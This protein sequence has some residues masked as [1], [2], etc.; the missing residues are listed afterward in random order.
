MVGCVRVW[1][2]TVCVRVKLTRSAD[3][4]CRNRILSIVCNA[5]AFR[6]SSHSRF[7]HVLRS[8]NKCAE[9]NDERAWRLATCWRSR[10]GITGMHYEG[11]W[12]V[13]RGSVSINSRPYTVDSWQ[14]HGGA[15]RYR[16]MHWHLMIIWWLCVLDNRWDLGR[17][18]IFTHHEMVIAMLGESDA[19]SK[20]AE[21]NITNEYFVKNVEQLT[22][23]LFWPR[24]CVATVKLHLLFAIPNS[25]SHSASKMKRHWSSRN[26]EQRELILLLTGHVRRPSFI[27]VRYAMFPNRE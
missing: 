16:N 17:K 27:S 7:L 2:V 6:R 15:E 9:Q 18:W 24:R 10:P 22:F 11:V 14:W 25:S 1:C 23:D 19:L 21:A 5:L 8:F 20:Q 3:N 26:G 13:L 4:L 12:C